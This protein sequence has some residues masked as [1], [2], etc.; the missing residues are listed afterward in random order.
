MAVFLITISGLVAGLWRS[1]LELQAQ[2]QFSKFFGEE[3]TLVGRVAEDPSY[4]TDGDLRLKLK[5]VTVDDEN[6]S[7]VVWVAT[8]QRV[9]SKRSDEVTV[10]G[11]L[12]KGF[13]TIAAAVYRARVEHVTR[14]DYADVGRDVRDSFASNI[15]KSI[16]EPEASLG[17]GFL[18]GQKSELPEKLDNE[19]RLL[20]LTHIV[21]ASGYNLTIL[22]RFA[23]RLFSRVSRFTALATSG[24]LIYGFAQLTGFSPS[25]TRAALVTTL[26]LIAWY[27]GR[28]LHPLV[29]LPFSAAITIAINPSYAWGDIGWL[30]SFTSFIGVIM[31]SPLIHAYFWDDKKPGNIRQVFIETMSA[32]VLTLP[33]IAYVFSQYSPL[34]LPA[35]ILILPLIPLAMLFTF[36][37]GSLSF[38]TPLTSFVGLPAELVMRYMTTIVDKLAILPQ[39]SSEVEFTMTTVVVFYI[40]LIT[41]MVY[42]WRRTGYQFRVYNVIE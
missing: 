27:Y 36:I 24:L 8:S 3:V 21:V 41:V 42:L 34:A 25:M 23:R 5:E 15:R 18:L 28:K 39:A 40:A 29:L 30:L 37:A 38:V 1:G 33:I 10:S 32:Q 14:Q 22:V 16:R 12:D 20:G 9:T 26:S 35:N 31:L 4:D 19:L 2:N 13:G 11:K 17:A 6:L 7:G